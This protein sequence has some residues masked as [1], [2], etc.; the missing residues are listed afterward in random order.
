M[1]VGQSTMSASLPGSSE[2]TWCADAVGDRRVDRAA[3]RGSAG[4]GRCRCRPASPASAA[5]LLLHLVRRSARQRVTVS[6]MRPIACESDEN[7]LMTPRSCSTSSAAIVSARMRD[8]RRRRR[9]RGCRVEVVA[10]HQ[11]VDRFVERVD[12]YGRVGL[13]D[14]GST[15]GSAGDLDDVRGVAAAGAL[16]VVACGSSGRRSP[17]SCPR[18]SRD[19]LSVSVWIATWTS[20]S[21][22]TRSAQSIT[23]G[24]VPQSSWTFRPQAPASICSRSALGQAAVALAEQPDVDRQR[25]DRPRASARCST[26]PGVQVV[27]VGAVGRAGAA[28]EQRG[29][30]VATARARPAAGR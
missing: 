12:V 24:V 23:A 19:S 28:A 17:R 10:D 30:A 8:C 5:A 25:L 6:P 29:D 1:S 9:P 16:G 7:M 11:H 13:V 3:W 4:R 15:L 18:G 26:A 27:A 2:P 14:D 21:S 22:A 20:Y